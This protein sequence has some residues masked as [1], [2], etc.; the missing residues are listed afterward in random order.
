MIR[1]RKLSLVICY[2]V[3]SNDRFVKDF[4]QFWGVSKQNK[5][6]F[7]TTEK[8]NVLKLYQVHFQM[9]SKLMNV[10]YR[11]WLVEKRGHKYKIII[12]FGRKFDSL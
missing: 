8:T 10:C 4:L 11:L 5:L 3:W 6:I 12:N 7:L 9:K 2:L 1:L